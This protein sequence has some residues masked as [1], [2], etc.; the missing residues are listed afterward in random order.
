MGKRQAICCL[1][2]QR[3]LS[4]FYL[5]TSKYCF[6]VSAFRKEKDITLLFRITVRALDFTSSYKLKSK[7]NPDRII[8]LINIKDR[9][10]PL[11]IYEKKRE[12]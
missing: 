11:S 5:Y 1:T 7:S 12:I 3:K 2:Q 9:N 10:F 6:L 8:F 4:F